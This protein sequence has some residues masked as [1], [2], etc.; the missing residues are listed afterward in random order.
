MSYIW[1]QRLNILSHHMHN[2]ASVHRRSL[3]S[4]SSSGHLTTN[5]R[6]NGQHWLP[7]Q[8]FRLAEVHR[9]VGV[10]GKT[11]HSRSTLFPYRTSPIALPRVFKSPHRITTTVFFSYSTA[12]SLGELSE[13]PVTSYLAK[14]PVGHRPLGMC[15][16][17]CC[18]VPTQWPCLVMLSAMEH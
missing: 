5:H 7:A 8:P 18:H 12:Q 15:L 1:Y 4:S 13:Y 2:T 17:N 16:T 9:S 14:E 10:R 3:R 11:V 6:L